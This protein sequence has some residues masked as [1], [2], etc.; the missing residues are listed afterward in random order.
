M[1]GYDSLLEW[2]VSESESDKLSLSDGRRRSRSEVRWTPRRPG[3]RWRSVSRLN[4]RPEKERLARI[5]RENQ[6]LLQK[7]LDCHLGYDRRRTSH[8]PRAAR[9]RQIRNG[10]LYTWP[11]TSHFLEVSLYLTSC[12]STDLPASSKAP[13]SNQINAK[14]IK[15]KTDYENLL[16]LKKILSAKP[17]K[18]VRD[19]RRGLAEDIN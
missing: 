8:I 11:L 4:G 17:S 3:S 15:Q 6:I 5:E 1:S 13:S 9:S 19:C 16:L 10:T 18:Y 14:Q 7:I 12:I 2:T